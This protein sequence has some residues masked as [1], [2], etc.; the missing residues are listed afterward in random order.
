MIKNIMEKLYGI[1]LDRC[2]LVK[3]ELFREYR[4]DCASFS[5]IAEVWM[6]KT[7]AMVSSSK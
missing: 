7:A 1:Q 4:G 2:R 6:V 3:I 5:S